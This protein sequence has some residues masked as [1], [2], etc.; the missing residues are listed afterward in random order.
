MRPASA[1]TRTLTR[2]LAI[3]A[4]LALAA[5]LAPHAAAQTPPGWWRALYRGTASAGAAGSQ[6]V[7]LD[8][9][10][11]GDEATGRL[12]LPALRAVL[13][14]SGTTGQDG[15]VTL[16]LTAP[17][18]RGQGPAPAA[19]GSLEGRRSLAPNDDGSRFT[20]QLRLGNGVAAT[21]TLRRIAQYVRVDVHDGNIHAQADF[22]HFLAPDLA[23]LRPEL[24]PP[25]Q[26]DIASFVGE[27]RSAR[28]ANALFHAYELIADTEL[29]GMAGAYVSLKSTRYRYTGGAHGIDDIETATWW[30]EPSGPRK[31]SLAELFAPGAPYVTRLSPLVLARLKEQDA[32]WVVQGQVTRLSAQDLALY[33]LTPAGIAFAFPPYAM[34]PYAQGTFTVVVPYTRVL[35][36]AASQGALQAFAQAGR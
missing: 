22:P 10:L 19:T 31:L 4:A 5:L 26:A 14:A 13:D 2:P 3:A 23:P 34:G 1:P 16:S 8:L 36:M 20:G 21:V 11:Q 6:T 28:A 35:D 33:A 12:L 25:A 27:G 9:T 7:V 30:L 32:T 18:E 15:A 29:E 17:R 24:A